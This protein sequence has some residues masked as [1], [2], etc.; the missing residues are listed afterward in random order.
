MHKKLLILVILIFFSCNLSKSEQ[1]NQISALDTD[2]IKEYQKNE[3]QTNIQLSNEIKALK[4]ISET[5]ITTENTTVNSNIDD[6]PHTTTILKIEKQNNGNIIIN[7]ATRKLL[8]IQKEKIYK[9]KESIQYGINFR[10]KD[11]RENQNNSVST[12]YIAVDGYREYVHFSLPII[13]KSSNNDSK[14]IDSYFG[15]TYIIKIDD[16]LKIIDIL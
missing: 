4:I 16:L 9:F 5:T 11:I 14:K 6:P 15:E 7:E 3:S 12:H 2:K 13:T 8:E 10:V 1:N